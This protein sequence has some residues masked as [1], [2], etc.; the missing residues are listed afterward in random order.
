MPKGW[1]MLGRAYRA[2]E[3]FEEAAEALRKAVGAQARTTRIC[4]RIR[5]KS[6]ALAERTYAGR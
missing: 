2:M 5:P 3:R 4:S 6:L 1:T